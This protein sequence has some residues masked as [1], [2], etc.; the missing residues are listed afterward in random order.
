[1]ISIVPLQDTS[2]NGKMITDTHDNI[3][4]ELYVN[5]GMVDG[6]RY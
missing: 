5:A 3:N 6:R 1:M 2:K 4:K